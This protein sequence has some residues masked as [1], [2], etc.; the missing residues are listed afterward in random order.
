M[1]YE[2]DEEHQAGRGRGADRMDIKTITID[3][4]GTSTGSRSDSSAPLHSFE[5]LTGYVD[6]ISIMWTA[7]F[8]LRVHITK[9]LRFFLG[10]ILF[11]LVL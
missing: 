8:H 7:P 4:R 11:T 6:S 9:F 1:D 10:L 2:E 5:C 3:Y